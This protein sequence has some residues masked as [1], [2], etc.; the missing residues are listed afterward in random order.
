M[1]GYITFY[2]GNEPTDIRYGA[3]DDTTKRT[4]KF[5]EVFLGVTDLSGTFSLDTVTNPGWVTYNGVSPSPYVVTYSFNLTAGN[6]A[7]DWLYHFI[8]K[9][10]DLALNPTQRNILNIASWN[11]ASTYT[12]PQMISDTLLLN[13][14]DVVQLGGYTSYVL[15]GRD[16]NYSNVCCQI[17][18]IS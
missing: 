2:T 9:N 10:G 8:T 3:T 1:S 15:G 4:L 7:T 5:S 13:P 6:H 17:Y 18:G 16:W 11:S 12:S 14:G